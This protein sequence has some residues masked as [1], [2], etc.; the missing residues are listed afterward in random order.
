MES[1]PA[2]A[3]NKRKGQTS[4]SDTDFQERDESE[5]EPESEEEAAEDVAA[6]ELESD[7]HRSRPT[8]SSLASPG[9]HEMI[10]YDL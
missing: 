3:R 8:H 5:D 6:R 9:N 7:A 2:G 4:D 1:S 10:D